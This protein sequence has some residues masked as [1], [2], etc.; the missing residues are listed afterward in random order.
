MR[1]LDELPAGGF[2]AVICMDNALPHLLSEADLAQ[3]ARQIRA[4][5]R[6]G[7]NLIASLRDYDELVRERPVVQGPVFYTD[8][9]QRRIV[10]QLWDWRDERQYTFHQYITRE[11]PEGWSNFHS[12]SVYRAV[13]RDEITGILST[14]GFR[15]IRW[16]FPAES[17]FYQPI[18][19]A[20]AGY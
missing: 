13:L 1:K 2:D 16:R 8:A 17:G 18:V 15:D 4:K 19:I 5:L 20:A 9:G 14:S 7:G 6:P 11:T 12:S 10:F 3:A